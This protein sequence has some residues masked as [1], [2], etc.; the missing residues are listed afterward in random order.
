MKGKSNQFKPTRV[1]PSVLGGKKTKT[2][3]QISF[4]KKGQEIKKETKAPQDAPKKDNK[5]P[6]NS[7]IEQE[8]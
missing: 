5:L 8:I 6:K 4:F 2:T 1:V 3:K 7:K